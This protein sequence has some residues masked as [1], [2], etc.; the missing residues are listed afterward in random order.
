MVC[1]SIMILAVDGP[2][3]DITRVGPKMVQDVRLQDVWDGC[4][5]AVGI[6]SVVVSGA[7]DGFV[8]IIGNNVE[9]RLGM[10]EAQGAA[11]HDGYGVVYVVHA[12]EVRNL[13]AHL[14]VSDTVAKR[15]GH[16]YTCESTRLAQ[17]G[18]PTRGVPKVRPTTVMSDGRLSVKNTVSSSASAP[19]S[20]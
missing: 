20:E 4:D 12:S 10:L 9:F 5:C 6:G 3:I 8:G 11:R 15:R 7:R 13:H 16:H 19:P 2:H 1:S 18:L 14:T 17:S